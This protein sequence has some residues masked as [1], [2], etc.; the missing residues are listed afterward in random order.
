MVF[1]SR[2]LRPYLPGRS[3]PQSQPGLRPRLRDGLRA[4]Q[5]SARASW[6][7]ALAEGHLDGPLVGAAQDLQLERATA[8]RLERVEQVVP[9]AYRAGP[10]RHDQVA[11][12]EA[13]PRG[14]TVVCDVPDEQALGLR[15]AHG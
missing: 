6:R 15:Q 4:G 7:S 5:R 10:G 12:G 8:G 14:R 13:G 3:W 1:L 2:P 9:G 11:L